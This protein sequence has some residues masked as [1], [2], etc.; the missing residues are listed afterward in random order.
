VIDLFGDPAVHRQALAFYG[1]RATLE[2]VQFMTLEEAARVDWRAL[3]S[4]VLELPRIDD[5]TSG[6]DPNDIVDLNGAAHEFAGIVR[7]RGGPLARWV[8]RTTWKGSE[9]KPIH[10]QRIWNALWPA[11]REIFAACTGLTV[12]FIAKKIDDACERY[13]RTRKV[14]GY[15]WEAHNLLDGVGL[16]LFELRRTGRAGV[17]R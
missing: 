5:Q 14:T 2:R 16:G 6:K 12:D 1:A 10:H 3:Q 11:E 15:S 17:R 8:N 9:K 4:L 7:G 13:A